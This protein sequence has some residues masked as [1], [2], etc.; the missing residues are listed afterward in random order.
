MA[1][2]TR[3]GPVVYVTAVPDGAGGPKL[4]INLND[5][6]LSLAFV[7]EEKRA[8]KLT[9]SLDNNDLELF[10]DPA[11]RKGMILEVTWGYAGNMTPTRTVVVTKIKGARTLTVEANAKSVLM[12]KR[13]RTRRFEHQSRADIVRQIARDNGYDGG[14][15]FIEDTG[16]VHSSVQQARLTDAQFI[17]RLA[18]LEHFEFYVDHEGFHFHSR[19]IGQQPIR[20]FRYFT[21]KRGDILDF[22]IE[23]DITARPA[24][25][26]TTL[27]GRDPLARTDIN[28]SAD[29]A[30]DS[31]RETL[32]SMVD[33]INPEEATTSTEVVAAADETIP[34]S[35][36]TATSAQR[37][38]RGRFR[39]V[40]QVA[41]KMKMTIIGDP[42]IYAKT[43]VDVQGMGLRVSG[44]YYVKKVSSEVS[45]SGYT[46]SLELISDGHGGHSTES[47]TVQGLELL[48]NGVASHGNRNNAP[49]QPANPGNDSEPLMSTVETVESVDAEEAGTRITY[50]DG[51]GRT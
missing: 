15:V 48:E 13:T 21:D 20:T 28:A 17:R 8:D 7:D 11:F 40:Q 31:A 42:G 45:S 16:E 35:Q 29:N 5:R 12:N 43:I 19:K 3:D 37:E 47:K 30:S 51:N 38:A 49:A 4:R 44:R 32:S 1:Q 2:I 34:T 27:R 24:P 9:L 33:R 50:R 25:A 14:N 36:A 10:D 41:V 26:R 39:K 18:N 22:D 23:N 46:Q 6:L